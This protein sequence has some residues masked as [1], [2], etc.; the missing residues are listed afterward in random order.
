MKNV[1]F[2]EEAMT[3]INGNVRC[4]YISL[5]LLKMSAALPHSVLTVLLL[6][7]GISIRQIAVIQSVYSIAIVLF[8]FPS[9]VL[10]DIL[11]RKYLFLFSK[12][13][14]FLSFIIIFSSNSFLLITGAWFLYGICTA[15]DTGTLE[16]EI[17]NEIKKNSNSQDESKAKIAKFVT[18]TA[19]FSLGAMLI[20]STAGS[21]FFFKI[22][23]NIYVA[24]IILLIL[25]CI[26]ILLKFSVTK[27]SDCGK[28]H[29]LYTE[30]KRHITLSILELRQTRLLKYILLLNAVSQ[31]FFQTHFQFWQALFIHKNIN[32][33]TFYIYYAIFQLAAIGVSYVPVNKIRSPNMLRLWMFLLPIFAALFFFIQRSSS[34]IFIAIYLF[35][36]FL[37]WLLIIYYTFVYQQ[38]VSR[39]NISALTSFNSFCSR[40]IAVC[41]LWFS[42]F[43]LAFFDIQIVVILNFSIATAVTFFWFFYVLPASKNRS[44][45]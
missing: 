37:F 30:V 39:E 31:F 2:V 11:N 14:L 7:K 25:S 34:F 36:V 6:E 1:R 23:I 4:Y 19:R 18:R 43:M 15:L 12:I 17:I 27:N 13:F 35:F 41:V 38:M 29:N 32:K 28:E 20:A 10:S 9:G 22:G 45:R 16:S 3:N 33:K 24:S 26:V 5:F 21:F 8:E 42:G 40:I 44:P